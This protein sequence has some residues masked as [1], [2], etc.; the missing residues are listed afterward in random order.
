V[1][2]QAED[3]GGELEWL[4]GGVLRELVVEDAGEV[5]VGEGL[6]GVEDGGCGRA[7]PGQSWWL[8]EGGGGEFEDA[9][10]GEEAERAVAEQG[11]EFEF[12]HGCQLPSSEQAMSARRTRASRRA[13]PQGP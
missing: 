7:A 11:G 13:S 6:G 4:L 12:V 9:E 1:A 5:V 2:G 3:A 8:W 10:C